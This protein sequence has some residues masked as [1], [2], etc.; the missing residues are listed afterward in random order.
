[1]PLHPVTLW[2]TTG[3]FI[4]C[5]C[6]TKLITCAQ[7]SCYWMWYWCARSSVWIHGC[8][9]RGHGA[10]TMMLWSLVPF[11]LLTWN[12]PVP[13]TPVQGPPWGT[14]LLW[15]IFS[16]PILDW[17]VPSCCLMS[18]LKIYWKLAP[19]NNLTKPI[20]LPLFWCHPCNFQWFPWIHCLYHMILL[21]FIGEM[22]IELGPLLVAH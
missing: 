13:Q 4:P 12:F 20:C 9:I 21:V 18:R 16:D 1:M 3:W 2:V 10:V 19:N 5:G 15:S 6:L 17:K 7:F 22:N 14:R 11:L 8:N